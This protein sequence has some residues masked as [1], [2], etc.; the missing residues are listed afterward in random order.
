[1][2]PVSLLAIRFH[3]TKSEFRRV[4]CTLFNKSAH[5]IMWYAQELCHPLWKRNMQPQKRR[6]DRGAAPERAAATEHGDSRACDTTAERQKGRA[7]RKQALGAFAIFERSS[8]QRNA[9]QNK[10]CDAVK[11]RK[12]SPLSKTI[13][14]S[15]MSVQRVSRAFRWPATAFI[16]IVNGCH[17]ITTHRTLHEGQFICEPVALPSSRKKKRNKCTVHTMTKLA[18]IGGTLILPQQEKKKSSV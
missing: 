15:F 2:M 10:V 16:A 3:V 9:N 17:W 13:C 8:A 5:T 11:S 12:P 1:M 7:R 14:E 4:K 6:R 18:G